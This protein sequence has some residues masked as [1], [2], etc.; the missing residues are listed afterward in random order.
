MRSAAGTTEDR[1]YGSDALLIKI[2]R[3]VLSLLEAFA[4]ARSKCVNKAY[5]KAKVE[6]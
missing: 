1:N 6:C 4:E 2:M 5:N 3:I